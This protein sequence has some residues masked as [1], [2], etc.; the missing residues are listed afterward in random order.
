MA[1]QTLSLHPTTSE[2]IQYWANQSNLD[3][4]AHKWLS[5][6]TNYEKWSKTLG[7]TRYV[8]EA[9]TDDTAVG[10]IEIEILGSYQEALINYYIHPEH[11][12]NG[13]G[14]KL[15]SNSVDWLKQNTKLK[16]AYG[17]VDHENLRSLKVLS[18]TNFLNQGRVKNF[19]VFSHVVN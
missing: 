9:R 4:S 6:C 15:M 18:S 7:P 12:G 5:L 2:H 16:V 8:L 19:I 13:Y 3:P 11:R 17:Y 1:H 14:K 10:F